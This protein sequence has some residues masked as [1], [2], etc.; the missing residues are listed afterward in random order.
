VKARA[1]IAQWRRDYNHVRPHSAH[2]GLAPET[3][4]LNHAA[5]RLRDVNSCAARPLPPEPKISY[6]ACGLPL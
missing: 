4:R 2:G 1:V 5:G 6:V 3:V